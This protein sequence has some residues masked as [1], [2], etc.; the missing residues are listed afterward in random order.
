MV[1]PV[2]RRGWRREGERLTTAALEY[3]AMG[4]PVCLGAFP[5]GSAPP[6]AGMS[7]SRARIPARPL[8]SRGTGRACSCD[9]VGCPAPAA[10]PMSPTWQMFASCDAGTVAERWGHHPEANIILPTGRVFDVLD[11]PVAAGTAALGLMKQ[12]GVEPGPVAAGHGRMLFFVATRGAPEDED[13]WWPCQLDCAPEDVG[14]VAGLRWHCRNSFV[15]APPSRDVTG[16]A[17]RW[18]RPPAPPS[19]V[20]AGPAVTEAALP[21]TVL[22]GTALAEAALA[23]AAL[24]EAALAETALPDAVRLLELLADACD[25]SRAS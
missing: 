17:G 5:R 2:L 24:A 14:E 13:E 22:P 18:I 4:W 15:L 1:A 25:E 10:H 20:L 16:T 7:R 9:R 19:A 21:G 8:R 3:A 6:M 11:V 23:E 12:A